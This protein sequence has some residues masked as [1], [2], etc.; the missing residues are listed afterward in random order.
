[1]VKS[2]LEQLRESIQKMLHLFLN[3][4]FD[5]RSTSFFPEKMELTPMTTDRPNT[6]ITELLRFFVVVMDYDPLSLCITGHP[7]QE[8]TLSSGNNLS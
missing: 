2:S 8:L 6:N 7:E 1:M 5:Y 3:D 4:S